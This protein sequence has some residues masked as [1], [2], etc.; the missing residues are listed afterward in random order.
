ME[1]FLGEIRMFAGTFAPVGWAF[2]SGQ[3]APIDQ[4][5]ALYSLLSTNYGG[6]GRTTFGLP[7]MRGRA[8]IHCGREKGPGVDYAPL[9][10]MP[11]VEEVL[12]S[13]SQL[14]SHSHTFTASFNSA[15]NQGPANKVLATSSDKFFIY[16]DEPDMVQMATDSIDFSGGNDPHY[17]MMPYIVL[18]F[19]IATVGLYPSRS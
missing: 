8:P 2:C 17:N 11:G 9:G 4:N 7:D 12:L 13:G 10:Y 5:Q 15:S 6:D 18:N 19:I 16:D 3:L 1:P 14:P